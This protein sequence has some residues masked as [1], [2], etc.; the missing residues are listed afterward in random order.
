MGVRRGDVVGLMLTNRPEFHLI[1]AAVMHLGAISFSVYN[2][3][4]TDQITYLF[5]NADP[6]VVFTENQFHDKVLAAAS[7]TGLNTVVCIDGPQS[8]TLDDVAASGDPTFDF[9]ATWKAVQPDD[10]LTLIYTSGTTGNPKGVELTHA[11]LLYQLEV[12]NG[13]I[14][15]LPGGR[16]ISYLPDAHLINRW[17]CQ[18]APMYFGIT[19]T[20]LDNPKAL[21]GALGTVR[22]TFFVAVPMLWYKMKGNIELTITGQTGLKGVLARRALAIGKKKAASTI[23]GTSLNRVDGALAAVAD[24]LVL[25]KLRAKL[26]FDAVQAAVSGAAPIDIATLEFMLA[27][28]IPVMEAW[29]MS[30]TSAVTTV[31]PIGS[32]RYGTVGKP[33]P[34]TEVSLE[35]DGEVLVR[36]GGVM[37]GYRKDAERT[38]ETLD[39]EGWIHTGDIGTLDAQGYLKI[40]DRKKELI[41]NSGGKNMSPSNIEGALKAASP[42]IGSV[43]AI[44]DNR[45]YVAA[46]ITLDPEAIAMLAQQHGIAPPSP[47]DAASVPA[48][49]ETVTAAVEAANKRLSRVES[50]RS[51]QILPTY[52]LPGGDELT[53]TMKLKRVPI[54]Q[55]YAESIESLYSK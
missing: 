46:L 23:A 18:Y 49:H 50:I 24:K 52:W 48:V 4:S 31:N 41:I 30:E 7:A 51:W 14:D 54:G 44:G 12:I 17:I 21:I 5:S 32:P 34:G 6:V 55:K 26:G 11:N 38:G 19:V 13:V 22:P 47:E 39:S 25:S 43:V 1:D 33:I 42:L 15:G 28:G 8:P 37:K 45:P 16:V 9:E 53:P 40:V 35:S 29:G 27:V 20:D 2:T 10:V 3:S 36:G